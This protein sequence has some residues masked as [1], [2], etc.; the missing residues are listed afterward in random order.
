MYF[1]LHLR[2]LGS[3][4]QLLKTGWYFG[5][6]FYRNEVDLPLG[7]FDLNSFDEIEMKIVKG[8]IGLT[9]MTFD[10]LAL[11]LAGVPALKGNYDK[12]LRKWYYSKATNMEKMSYHIDKVSYEKL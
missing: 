8:I 11:E 7:L 12:K 9:N 10:K 2:K 3:L 4:L 5:P 1:I 6:E